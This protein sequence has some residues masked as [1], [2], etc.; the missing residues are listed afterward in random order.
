MQV[1]TSTI[2]SSFS[3]RATSPGCW[4]SL[5]KHTTTHKP[6]PKCFGGLSKRQEYFWNGCFWHVLFAL[7]LLLLPNCKD[8][9]FVQIHVPLREPSIVS[10]TLIWGLLVPVDTGSVQRLFHLHLHIIFSWINCCKADDTCIF[11]RLTQLSVQVHFVPPWVAEHNLFDWCQGCF[12]AWSFLQQSIPRFFKL[13][14]RQLLDE[15]GP[16]GLLTQN[17]VAKVVKIWNQ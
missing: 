4:F 9:E 11:I 17:T 5:F 3:G 12:C 2:P 8:D 6:F 7:I 13:S 14:T 15:A 1:I 16:H 10:S